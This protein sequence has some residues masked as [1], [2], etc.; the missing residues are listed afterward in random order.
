MRL[1]N[2]ITEILKDTSGVSLM[3]VM[4]IMLLLMFIG[5]SVLTSASSN[6]GANIRQNDYNRVLLLGDSIHR[7]IRFSLQEDPENEGLLAFQIA[8]GLSK[9]NSGVSAIG[10]IDLQ[11]DI[12]NP[13]NLNIEGITLSFPYVSVQVT[14]A[15]DYVPE[16]TDDDGE[17]VLVPE[18]DRIPKTKVV[19]ARMLVTVVIRIENNLMDTDRIITTR[20]TYILSDCFLTDDPEG[21]FSKTPSEEIDEQEL[22]FGFVDNGFGTWSMVSYETVES[23]AEDEEDD[24]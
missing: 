14:E 8:E 24:G 16:I 5:T 22:V 11:I 15:R 9:Q 18:V 23:H 3:F 7:N 19:S 4:G 2:R 6:I 17:V 13:T 20:A 10:D 21:R 12:D 1:K